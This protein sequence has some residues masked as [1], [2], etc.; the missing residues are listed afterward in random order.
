[1]ILEVKNCFSCPFAN[2][3]NEYGQDHCSLSFRLNKG[4]DLKNG[5]ELPKDKRHEDCP[6]EDKIEIK[7]T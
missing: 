6:I 7:V 3:D 4:V 1:M 5:E 2:N